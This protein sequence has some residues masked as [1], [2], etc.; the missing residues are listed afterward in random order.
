MTGIDPEGLDIVRGSEVR[1]VLFAERA[2]TPKPP[3]ELVKLAAE[4]RSRGA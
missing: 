2:E 1:R 3:E 4:A